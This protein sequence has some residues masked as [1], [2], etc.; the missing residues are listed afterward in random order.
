M[1]SGLAAELGTGGKH[2]NFARWPRL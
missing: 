2:T 1:S